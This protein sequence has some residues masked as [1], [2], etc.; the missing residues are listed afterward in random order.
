MLNTVST[1]LLIDNVIDPAK[2]EPYDNFLCKTEAL[3]SVTS[4][5]NV[6]QGIIITLRS[7][8]C[9][10]IIFCIRRWATNDNLQLIKCR[11]LM[12]FSEEVIV[13]HM[14]PAGDQNIACEHK[15]NLWS[16]GVESRS[17]H[18]TD[19]KIKLFEQLR[20]TC[21]I[22]HSQLNIHS[23]Y[24]NHNII[25]GLGFCAEIKDIH[26]LWSVKKIKNT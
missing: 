14:P 10:R 8:F 12:W 16:I 3:L 21:Q 5:A 1:Q 7:C 22:N 24:I 15:I 6:I 23:S 9:Y 20:A 25:C 2:R 13:H 11:I 18:F 19:S 17:R 4:W 26:K